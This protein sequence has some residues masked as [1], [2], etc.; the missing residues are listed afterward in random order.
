HKKGLHEAGLGDAGRRTQ[1]APGH[2]H[3]LDQDRTRADVAAHFEIAAHGDDLLE[4]VLHVAGDGHFLNREL[5]FAAQFAAR[6]GA[7]DVGHQIA[8]LDEGFGVG[9]QAVT[10]ECRTAHCAH[11]L[12]LTIDVVPIVA[13]HLAFAFGDHHAAQ[14]VAGRG[15]TAN[16]AVAVA[17]HAAA[18]MHVERRAVGVLDPAVRIKRSG[19]TDQR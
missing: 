18:L 17:I 11:Q 6:V 3:L 15:V 16:E 9:G 10:V 19:F 4:H 13:L 2:H 12:A 8:I 5:N 14:A 1:S 7:Q